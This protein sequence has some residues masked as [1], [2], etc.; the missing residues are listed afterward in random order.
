MKYRIRHEIRGRIRLHVE[1]KGMTCREA[2]TLLYF[3][4][5]LPGVDT[6]K[7]YEQ[8]G[9]AVVRYSGD[10]EDILQ[11]L[12]SFRYEQVQV[13]EQVLENSGRELNRAYREKLIGRTLF[14]FGKKLLPFPVRAA[15]TGYK[16]VRYMARGLKSLTRGR[17]EVE[18]LD[19]AAIT[20]SILRAD[21]DTAG[22]VM[23]LLG[24]GEILEE[25]THK[26]RWGTWPG[27]CP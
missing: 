3:L 14:H 20:V 22:S 15:Y 26:S 1:Q 25:W 24:V 2:D 10:R 4:E 6:A 18:V 23:Y 8:T 12:R 11:A 27:V 7:V 9:D 17:L 16:S 13:P 21:F 19:A 5:T